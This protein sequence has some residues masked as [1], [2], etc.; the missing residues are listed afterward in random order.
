VTGESPEVIVPDEAP[1]LDDDGWRAL[2]AAL[3]GAAQATLG[4]DW[5][6]TL[7]ARTQVHG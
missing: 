4:S 6:S 5:R 2:L 3:V 1:P 7:T